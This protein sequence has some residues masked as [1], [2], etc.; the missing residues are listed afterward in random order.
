M[1]AQG[2][3]PP[4]LGEAVNPF[5]AKLHRSGPCIERL[6]NTNFRFN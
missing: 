6:Q 5:E 3:P 1:M 2:R 4:E